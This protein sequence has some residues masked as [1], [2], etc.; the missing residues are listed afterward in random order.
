MNIKT[1]IV[2]TLA[3][4]LTIGTTYLIQ[5]KAKQA[6]YSPSNNLNENYNGPEKVNEYLNILRGNPSTGVVD[7]NDYYRAR[8]EVITLSKRKNKAAIGMQWDQM[9]PDNVGGRTRAILVDKNNSNIVYAGSIAGGLF[10]SQDA[11]ATWNPV[12]SLGDNLAISCIAQTDDGRIFFGTGSAFETWTGNGQGTP[13]FPGNGLYEYVPSSQTVS[14]IITNTTS[15]VNT[16]SGSLARIN[17]IATYGNRI[18]LGLRNGVGMVYADPDGSGNYPTAISGWTNPVVI[19]GPNIPKTSEV[20]DIDV[21]S[22]GSVLVCYAGSVW[23]SP[24]GSPSSFVEMETTPGVG[25]VNASRIS[26][27]IAPSNPNVIYVVTTDGSGKL[28]PSAGSTARGFWISIDKGVTW[29]VIIPGGVSSIDPFVQNDGTGGQGGYDQAIAVDPN[30]WGR[31]LVGGIQMYQWTYNP[32]SSPIGGDW[33]KAANLFEFGNNPY[34]IHADKHTIAW[35]DASTIYVGS[36][37]GVAKSSDGG[38]TWL[39]MNLGYNVTTFFSVATAGN[40]FILGGAQ[41]NGTQLYDFGSLGLTTS[42]K[43]TIQ[44]Q[45]GDGFSCAFSNFGGGIAYSTSQF[46]SVTRANA[47]GAPGT[48]FDSEV[49]GIVNTGTPFN[50]KIRNWESVNDTLTVDSIQV[51]FSGP[52]TIGPGNPLVYTSLTNAEDLYY[53]PSV[54]MNVDTTDTLMLPDYIQNK[55]AFYVGSGN[56]YLTRDA[57]RLGASSPQWSK[58]GTNLGGVVAME[59]SPDGNSLYIGNS[60]GQV[61]RISG[62]SYSNNDDGLDV[63]TGTNLVTTKTLIASGLGGTVTG[64]AIDPN[65]GE[66]LVATVGNYGITNHV[67]RTTSAES[68]TATGAF[69]AIQ[70]PTSPSATGYLPSMPVYDA[71]IDVNDKNIVLI[72]TDFGVWGASNVFTAATGTQVE[73]FDE[74]TNGMAH[75]PVFEVVQQSMNPGV[76]PGHAINSQMYYLGTHGR[77]FYTSSSRVIN[78]V[79]ID[80]NNVVKNNNLPKLL[81]YPSPMS[82]NGKVDFDLFEAGKT[83]IKIYNLTGALA[84]TIDLGVMTAGNH[85]ENIN[86]ASLSVG[87]YIVSLE[88]GNKREV[89]KLII[90]R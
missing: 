5:S 52:T 57:A 77:G 85:K 48:F 41:D 50:T 2:A 15:P 10:V 23:L 79:G 43:G 16:T 55:F 63:S 28:T 44:I 12:N 25:F 65:N 49:Q 3:L 40:G 22:D 78:V 71:E 6:V 20:Q 14:P 74:S 4:S 72:G 51:T 11:G 39:E 18:Y 42:P 31:V 53:E 32:G 66:N 33:I 80:E 90:A 46:G 87:T 8:K 21:G 26:A 1:I 73:W 7:M 69:E 82:A 81:I 9:G 30:N 60:S 88:S 13:G 76:S 86:V 67:Y 34:Y 19:P 54:T 45:S 56:V 36:D 64:I 24:D 17:Q 84:K 70:G 29:N 37:G 83:T 47:G 68:A 58:I 35:K 61:Y 89:S 27:A 62:L 38:A 75:V 59:F